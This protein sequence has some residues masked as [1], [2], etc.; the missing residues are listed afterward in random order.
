M[1]HFPRSRPFPTREDFDLWLREAQAAV[2]SG[3]GA[4]KL[5]TPTYSDFLRRGFITTLKDFRSEHQRQSKTYQ[6]Y[7]SGYLYRSIQ[8]HLLEND[9]LLRTFCKEYLSI[10]L[11][12]FKFTI[13][14]MK[15]LGKYPGLLL[16]DSVARFFDSKLPTALAKVR[17]LVETSEGEALRSQA[18]YDLVFSV[19]YRAVSRTIPAIPGSEAFAPRDF[20][21]APAAGTASPRA[22][23]TKRRKT[24]LSPIKE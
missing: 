5:P 15:L 22:H 8:K 19:N 7:R 20:D 17:A 14:A 1:S 23:R 11:A 6:L 16:S 2:L 12:E 24:D 9:K 3:G 18:V 4:F 13:E 10:D 21:G